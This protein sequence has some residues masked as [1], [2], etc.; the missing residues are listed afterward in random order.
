MPAIATKFVCSLRL[1]N[2][3]NGA[4]INFCPVSI[5]E[6]CFLISFYVAAF[7]NLGNVLLTNPSA[8][9]LLYFLG[10]FFPIMNL[11][12]EKLW[13]DSRF[14]YGDDIYH[15]IFEVIVLAALA[16]SISYISPTEKMSD[17][18]S[19]VEMF[20]FSISIT[21]CAFLNIVRSIECYFWGRGQRKIIEAASLR[22][23]RWK[24]M[25]CA[26]YVSAS[27][28]SGIAYFNNKDSSYEGSVVEISDGN[29]TASE[30]HNR[31][32]AAIESGKANVDPCDKS[33]TTDVPILL[34]LLG[35]IFNEL[36]IF[37]YIRFCIPKNGE[38]K[39]STIPMNIDFVI[40]RHGEWIMLVLGESVLSLLIVDGF[41][42]GFFMV[43]YCGIVTVVLLQYLHFRSQP[44]HPDS[45]ALRRHK[46][47][48]ATYVILFAWYSAALIVVGAS[49]KMF[50]YESSIDYDAHRR[51]GWFSFL[52][53]DNWH[54]G[55]RDLAADAGSSCGP[56]GEERKENTAYLYCGAMA[57]VFFCMDTIVL[58]HVGLRKEVSRCQFKDAVCTVTGKRS[59]NYNYKGIVV[60][61]FRCAITIFMATLSLWMSDPEYLA[62]IGL[63]AVVAQLINR[64]LGDIFFPDD[65]HFGDHHHHQKEGLDDE[66]DEYD[67]EYKWPNVTHPQATENHDA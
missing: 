58:C 12:H 60:V 40:H 10:C 25:L 11:W 15:K 67:E 51:L 4:M 38:H 6:I 35:Y 3:K 48:G 24:L 47:A 34:L 5:G 31:I 26:F 28:T 42:R 13:Y 57:I 22:D 1:A 43:F 46:D 49:Y 27:I 7:Y 65:G 23:L 52:P 64:F 44:H 32:M 66:D 17:P 14:V 61:T 45:H 37:V 16:T 53:P 20:G 33:G 21:F 41:A 18:S 59:K 54:E 63:A 36:Y 29:E 39:N 56:Y 55:I 62:E 50:L 19:Y 2:V 30:E 9:G 8:T